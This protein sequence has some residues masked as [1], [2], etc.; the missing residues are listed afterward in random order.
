MLRDIQS[1]T[2][3]DDGYFLPFHIDIELIP[4]MF[5]AMHYCHLYLNQE[6]CSWHTI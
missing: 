1:L 3:S 2:L 6:T 4:K 5:Y